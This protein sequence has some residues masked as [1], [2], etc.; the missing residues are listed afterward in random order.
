[1][2][3]EAH[4]AEGVSQTVPRRGDLGLHR[5]QLD[6]GC[7]EWRS[8]VPDPRVQVV[9]GGVECVTERDPAVR[10]AVAREG[11]GAA[12]IPSVK[13][14]QVG[15]VVL[16]AVRRARD[17]PGPEPVGVRLA[18]LRLAHPPEVRLGVDLERPGVDSASEGPTPAV[19]Q[20]AI[21]RPGQRVDAVVVGGEPARRL[22]VARGEDD[23][24]PQRSEESA[25]RPG[26]QRRSHLREDVEDEPVVEDRRVGGEI[27]GPVAVRVPVAKAGLRT[28]QADALCR[29]ARPR[30][31]RAEDVA[32]RLDPVGRRTRPL[33]AFILPVSPR[34]R[35]APRPP[36]R[37]PD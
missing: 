3:R 7:T 27:E 18:A 4:A 26:P 24:R 19:D 15:H 5:C 36:R 20:E 35:S 14:G 1:M 33:V 16:I 29:D 28:V 34:A 8:S 17:L 30:V 10:R 21:D 11:Q 31:A 13:L 32:A 23:L 37:P 9:I 25:G 2:V 12:E 22:G 6:R